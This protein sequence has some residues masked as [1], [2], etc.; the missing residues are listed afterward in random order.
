ML[1]LAVGFGVVRAVLDLVDIALAH[2]KGLQ[3]LLE[4][5]ASNQQVEL[6][7]GAQDFGLG[8]HR[9][10]HRLRVAVPQVLAL[11][12]GLKVRAAHPHVA[13]ARGGHEQGLI[14]RHA[15]HEAFTP[16]QAHVIEIAQRRGGVVA[17]HDGDVV[18]VGGGN[19]AA[20]GSVSW[21]VAG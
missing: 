21:R 17:V 14:A 8:T 4:T 10:V 15:M 13:A 12:Y 5:A 19:V 18:V 16:A 9:H 3:H 6:L 20:H 1:D 11:A 2:G 7:A